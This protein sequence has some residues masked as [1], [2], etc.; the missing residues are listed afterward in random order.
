MTV[1]PPDRVEV[2]GRLPDFLNRLDRVRVHYTLAHTRPE[3]VM[4]DI[5][6]PGWRWE[7]EFMADGSTEIERFRSVSGVEDNAALLEELL[8]EAGGNLRSAVCAD[9]THGGSA[10]IFMQVYFLRDSGTNLLSNR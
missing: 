9:V 5:S 4:V 2:F 3:S 6:M 10:L 8:T 1:T 7:V